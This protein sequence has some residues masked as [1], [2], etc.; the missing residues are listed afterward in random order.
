[1]LSKV[2]SWILRILGKEVSAEDVAAPQKI[3][4]EI[5]GSA[6]DVI[7]TQEI[8][9]EIRKVEEPTTLYFETTERLATLQYAGLCFQANSKH[10]HKMRV[11]IYTNWCEQK[12]LTII[13]AVCS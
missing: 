1:M 4:E 3:L 6:G 12:Q 8:L 9:E 7:T 2:A 10:P 11:G 13:T 5:E